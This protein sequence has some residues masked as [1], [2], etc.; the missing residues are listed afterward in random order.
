M[1]W[2][3]YNWAY[4]QSIQGY[5]DG[6]NFNGASYLSRGWTEPRNVVYMESHDEERLMFRA[7]EYGNA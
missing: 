2:S 1:L 3:N 7:L 4:S 5:S 6:A